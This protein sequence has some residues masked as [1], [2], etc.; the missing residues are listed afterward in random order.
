[1]NE[2][3][4]RRNARLGI[5]VLVGIIIFLIG[6]FFIGS[7]RNLFNSNITLYAFFTNVDGLQKGNNIWLSGVKIGTV[8]DVDIVND[9]LVRVNL[10]VREDQAKF[11]HKDA[12]ATLGSDGL[13]GN[14]I[15]NLKPGRTSTTVQD[16]DTIGVATEFGMGD[17][18]SIAEESGPQLQRTLA[19]LADMTSNLKDQLQQSTGMIGTLLN[20]QQVAGQMKQT[21]ANLETSSQRARVLTNQM[22]QTLSELR[23][24][25]QGV[26]YTLSNDTA[27]ATTYTRALANVQSSTQNVV[28]ATDELQALAQKMNGQNNAISTLTQNEEFAQNLERAMLNAKDAGRQLDE[29]LEA[30]E[31]SFFL[32][33]AFRKKNKAEQKAYEDSVKRANN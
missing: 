6:I 10:K 32:R 15:V 8:R 12:I 19:N 28:R 30:L 18:M 2:Q 5:F 21:V 14:A 9:S 13:V 16:G 4:T 22:N 1:M 33:G 29:T 23:N 11:I 24:N 31:Y 20:D 25:R 17:L 27:F 3:E 26:L 7:A